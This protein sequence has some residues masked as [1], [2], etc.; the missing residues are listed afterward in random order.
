MVC[1]HFPNDFYTATAPHYAGPWT[2]GTSLGGCDENK[3]KFQCP[4]SW[5]NAGKPNPAHQPSQWE[6]CVPAC[7]RHRFLVVHAIQR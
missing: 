7:S 3:A 1:D 6:E 4:P 5:P 2:I